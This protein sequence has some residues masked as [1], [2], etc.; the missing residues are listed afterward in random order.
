MVAWASPNRAGLRGLC[1]RAGTSDAPFSS[2]RERARIRRLG[3]AVSEQP[4]TSEREG[5]GGQFSPRVELVG[6]QDTDT[7]TDHNKTAQ[8]DRQLKKF[9]R[10]VDREWKKDPLA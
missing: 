3:K 10:S 4:E 1:A 2:L 5:C 7:Q 9:A 8:Q 6:Q